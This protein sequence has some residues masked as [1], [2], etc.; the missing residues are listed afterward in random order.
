MSVTAF[1]SSLQVAQAIFDAIPAPVFVKDRAHRLVV[2]NRAFAELAGADVSALVGKSDADFFPPEEVAAYWA[3][4]DRVL[5]TGEMVEAEEPVTDGQGHVRICR[6]RKQRV[7]ITSDAGEAEPFVVAVISDVTEIRRAEDRARRAE[8]IQAAEASALAA[9]SG[10]APLGDILA[11]IAS[12][13]DEL[14]ETGAVCSILLRD[15][16]REVLSNG[17]A[18]GL[19]PG[20]MAAVDGVPIGPRSGSCG[21]A[22]H[23]RRPVA[24]SDLA[25]D[26]LWDQ[27]RDLALAH[28]LRACAST[29]IFDETGDVL[30]AFA[31]YHRTVRATDGA[32]L[33]LVSRMS[34]L[35]AVAIARTRRDQA[36]RATRERLERLSDAVGAVMWIADPHV[37]AFAY[38][39]PSFEKLTGR[40]LADLM[41]DPLTW[42]K[43]IH[44]D[45]LPRVLEVT[46]QGW[47]A[48]DLEYRIIRSDGEVRWVH[49]VG[50]PV[51]DEEGKVSWVAGIAHDITNLK[52]ADQAA[53][54]SEERFREL[55]ETVED[56][57]WIS[58]PSGDAIH[59][60]SPGYQKVWGRSPAE[61]HADPALWIEAIHPED[62]ASF[63]GAFENQAQGYR[64]EYRIIRPGG[65]IR[66][67][68]DRGFPVRDASGETLRVVGLAQDI[69]YMKEAQAALQASRDEAQAQAQGRRAILDSARDAIITLDGEGRIEGVNKAGERMLGYSEPELI[70]R[71]AQMLIGSDP[72]EPRSLVQRLLD[73]RSDDGHRVYEINLLQKN[74]GQLPVDVNVGELLQPDGVHFVAV[75]RDSTER[76]RLERSKNEFISTVSHELRT[77][78]TSIAGSLGLLI[79]SGAAGALPERTSRLI[80]IAESNSRRLVRLINDILDI[81]KMQT[82]AM[83]FAMADVDLGDLAARAI[84]TMGGLASDLGVSYRSANL[85][86]PVIV[87]GDAD[88]LTQVLTNLLS[89]AAKFSP[90]GGEIEVAVTTSGPRARFSVRDHGQGISAE[91]R[92]RIFG[93]FA[94]ADASDTR[95]KGGT[96]LG[97]AICKE[98]TER[99]GGRIWFDSPPGQGA[100]FHV[101]LPLAVTLAQPVASA[102]MGGGRLLLCEDDV[103]V[104]A[105]LSAALEMQGF[106]ADVVHTLAA[107]DA[108]LR[109]P[110]RYSALLLDLRLPDGNGLDFLGR[111][112]ERSE[113]RALPVVIISASPQE[114]VAKGVDIVDWIQKPID[115]GRLRSAVGQAARAST[116]PPRVLYVDDDADLRR[117]VC[118]AFGAR[119]RVMTA[120]SLTDARRLLSTAMPDVA[121]LDIGLPDGSG[122]ELLPDLTHADGRTVPVVIFS[123]RSY[124]EVQLTEQIEA[125]L[126][127]S[128]TS[129]D[130]LA[131][132][133]SRLH[134][135]CA[136]AGLELAA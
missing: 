118:E 91:F 105:F 8:K 17:V 95:Q 4:D 126:T 1:A 32:D 73:A 41:A 39:S 116:E 20:Y 88:R 127:K 56:V 72:N 15:P 31:L 23:L 90:A 131:R 71:P 113:T 38:M 34:N 83:T 101:E 45:D 110:H 36:L 128:R 52:A 112:R 125:I 136:R 132:T 2:L 89:N 77:P 9:I 40:L 62:R 68:S 27:W 86:A 18:P 78:L 129:L 13:V 115:L 74:G 63:F 24:V 37:S 120:E 106:E 65:E 50:N 117:L 70:G 12:S 25:V 44:P 66:W 97:L 64:T 67:I 28:G 133:V 107:A 30:G 109:G 94:Q 14:S 84:E 108:A 5:R 57:F 92:D 42:A 47:Q 75:L 69:T 76:R 103:D 11:M 134:S 46:Q 19:P 82:G 22:A 59:Y 121:I 93:K 80:S 29:P 43:L 10:G 99:H 114:N 21:T 61:L 6:T 124:G 7:Y 130:E 60:V 100:T 122:V 79:G 119:A 81:E 26:P 96:G 48:Y 123:A 104:A 49:A 87:R 53:R 98:I 35:A 85:D 54:A 135:D 51:E 33:A 58:T 16:A 3:V 55:A 102:E 111:L